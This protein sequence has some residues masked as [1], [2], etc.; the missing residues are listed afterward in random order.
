MNLYRPR[1]CLRW[2][3]DGS[4]RLAPNRQFLAVGQKRIRSCIPNERPGLKDQLAVPWK[5]TGRLEEEE[6]AGSTDTPIDL[7]STKVPGPHGWVA[8]PELKAQ[9]CWRG[10]E[11]PGPEDMLIEDTLIAGPARAV[12]PA[13]RR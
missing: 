11:T 13:P 12:R 2:S 10:E 6:P 1:H 3:A 4:T 9:S 5:A 7:R 8:D